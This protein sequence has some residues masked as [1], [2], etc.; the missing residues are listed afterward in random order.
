M[1]HSSRTIKNRHLHPFSSSSFC[2]RVRW[3]HQKPI[4]MQ[5]F[6][7]DRWQPRTKGIK[8][9]QIKKN[10]HTNDWRKKT[11][12]ISIRWLS[13]QKRFVDYFV[14]FIYIIFCP[15]DLFIT[16]CM[17]IVFFLIFLSNASKWFFGHFMFFVDSLFFAK[18]RA[19]A[20]NDDDDDEEEEK[21]SDNKLS[22]NYILMVLIY[23]FGLIA[24]G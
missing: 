8:T 12:S 15:W 5:S 14:V 6:K 13:Y 17:F 4:S 21:R 1:H 23:A 19:T 3:M 9:K 7:A 2:G 16:S 20:E 18:N 24:I 10:E 11:N 22:I